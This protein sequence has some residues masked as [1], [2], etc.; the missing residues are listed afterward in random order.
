[1]ATL[2]RVR[3]LAHTGPRHPERILSVPTGRTVVRAELPPGTLLTAALGDV[4]APTGCT[5][6]NVEIFGGRFGCLRYVVPAICSDGS[7]PVTFSD[8]REASEPSH[9]LG[10]SA[11]LGLRDGEPFTHCHAT[12]VDTDGVLRG[13][14]LLPDVEVGD[15]PI[16]VTVR[17]LHDAEQTSGTD[18]ETDMPVFTP[19]PTTTR[20]TSSHPSSRAV[21][22]RVRPAVDLHAAVKQVCRRHGFASAVVRGGL[23]S[24]VGARLQHRDGIVEVDGPATELTSLIGRAR[25]D[26]SGDHHVTLSCTLVDRHG[27][28]HSGV[29]AEGENPVAVTFELYV[30]EEQPRD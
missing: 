4:L 20:R 26:S 23:G 10:G 5:S 13:G 12:W 24:V 30:E 22:A 17:A 19:A 29:L 9:L 7:K 28:I 3:P 6:A 18:P 16:E 2:A 25:T 15:V 27:V 21:V 8:V 11:T 1:M 14:H